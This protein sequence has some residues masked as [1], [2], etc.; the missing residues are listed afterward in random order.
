MTDEAALE[1]R[2]WRLGRTSGGPTRANLAAILYTS[3]STGGRRG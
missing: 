3:G 2:R 1:R